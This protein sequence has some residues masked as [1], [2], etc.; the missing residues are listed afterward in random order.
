[1]PLPRF[2][3]RIENRYKAGSSHQFLLHFNVDD[4]IWDDVYGYLPTTDFLMEQ[5][6]RLG[7]NSI[8]SYN[9]SEGITFPNLGLRG[10][11]QKA[12]GLSRIDE[13]EPLPEDMPPVKNI[14]A[15][16]R[17]VGREKLIRETEEALVTLERFMKGSP[18][19]V[20][21]GLIINNAERLVPNRSIL[22]VSEQLMDNLV[23]DTE[24]LQRWALDMRIKLRGHMILLMTENISDIAPELILSERHG[25]YSVPVP[26]PN[27]RQRLHYIRHLLNLPGDEEDENKYKLDLPEGTLSENFAAMTHGLSLRD[28]QSLWITSKRRKT[29]VSFN[30]VIQQ[31]RRSIPARSYG[32]LEL[33]YGEHGLNTVGGLE[34]TINYMKN[35][36]QAMRNEETKRVPRGILMVGP[37]G[38][39]KTALIHALSRDMGMHFINFRALHSIDPEMRSDW[40]MDRV[41]SVINSLQ[42]VIVFIDEID[43]IADT[44]AYNR[45]R[46]LMNR[47]MN[48]LLRTM[49][50]SARR[51]KVLWIAASNKPDMIDPEFRKRGRLD[52]VVPFLLPGAKEREDI[53]KKAFSKNAIPYDNR[54]KFATPA[55]RTQRFTGAELELIAMRSYQNAR[56]RSKDTVEEQDLVKAADEFVPEHDPITYEYMM[57]L[58]IRESNIASLV[59]KPLEGA[60]QDRVYSDNKID[61]TKINQRLRELTPQVNLRR[62]RRS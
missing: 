62:I 56:Q 43:R 44:S 48:N 61:K 21:V 52:D 23:T 25:T 28:I 14:N 27:P 57:L 2:W 18:S 51:G 13:V 53:L 31:N 47:A 34:G 55:G 9:R 32:R 58:A 17:K 1:M 29:A 33:I 6:N 41:Y 5:M 46:G 35:I 12:T 49:S 30:M 7:C 16:F 39:G 26:L 19:G 50:L 42:P 10:E 45:D 40:D 24:T 38:T 22:P 4:L 8:L 11:Y 37:S 3:Q 36:I 20:K 59:P 15:D 54:I 60:L